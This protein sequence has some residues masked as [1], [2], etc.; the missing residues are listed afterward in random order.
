M[1]TILQA[2]NI[3]KT[4]GKKGAAAYTAIQ[5]LSFSMNEG[6]FIG[7]MGPSGSGKTTLL[8]LVATLDPMTSGE[9]TLE[10]ISVSDMNEDQLSDFRSQNLGFIFQDFNLLENMTVFEN[11]ALPLS[12]RNTKLEKLQAGVHQVSAILG[13]GD[14]LEKNPAELS[15]GQKQRTTIA[16]SLIHEPTLVLADEPTGALDSQNAATLLETLADLNKDRKVSILMVTHDPRSASYC[17]RL[18][19]IK[20][21]KLDRELFPDG[22]REEFH[23]EILAVLG[24]LDR[25]PLAGVRA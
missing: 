13:I 21:G 5:D 25:R 3:S 8:N 23:Q 10:G 22:T 12:L 2:S 15:G 9:I 17:S 19:F 14:L 11:I 6:E 18:L 1:K 20:D 24:D 16:R 7:I 4:Y